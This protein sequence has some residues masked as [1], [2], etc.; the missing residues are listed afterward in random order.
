MWHSGISFF[1]TGILKIANN[2]LFLRE[3]ELSF[4]LECLY[5]YNT[6]CFIFQVSACARVQCGG[7][8]ST[9][10]PYKRWSG[11]HLPGESPGPLLPGPAPSGCL[12]PLSPSPSGCGLL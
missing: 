3:H 5:L 11:D 6:G 1:Q 7:F 9:M 2:C 8:C 12:V 10:E 4:I